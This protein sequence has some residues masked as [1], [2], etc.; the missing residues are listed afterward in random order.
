MK[1]FNYISILAGITLLF[2]ACED[3]DQVFDEIT[4]NETR[5]AV[6]RT[7]NINSNELPIGVA[8]A[9]F[10][11][12]LE[13]QDQEN[14]TLVEDVEV[15]I[16]FNDNTE[17]IGPGTNVTEVL[18]T[19]INKSTFTIGEFGLPR[20]NY[21]VT[22]PE[23]LSFVGRNG[24]DITGGDQFT[25]RFELILN[26]GRRYSAA[27]NSGTL[28]QTFFSSP[29]LYTPTVICPIPD[30]FFVGDYSIVQ[31]SGSSPFGIGDFLTQDVTVEANG[32]NRSF[33]FSYDPGGFDSAY[34]MSMDLICG[35]IT[36]LTGSINAGSLGCNG[37]ASSIGQTGTADVPYDLNGS[38]EVFMFE[39]EDFN[40]SADCGSAVPS[41][42]T[43]TKL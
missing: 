39:I 2:A 22:L 35:V 25:V 37:G 33:Q 3:G 4:D 7:V 15:Y 16:G 34:T 38:D 24:D 28:T 13:V 36:G 10:D 21:S 40:P 11:V 19:T 26:D 27:D 23:L 9:N 20:F 29:F 17:Q 14:G 43:M 18:F 30:T 8:D 1:K 12:D 5:G 6:L 42:F 32:T 41:T 31:T